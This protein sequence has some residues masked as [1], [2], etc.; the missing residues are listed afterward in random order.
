MISKYGIAVAGSA[1]LAATQAISAPTKVAVA[2]GGVR[3]TAA[4][5]VGKWA[6]EDDSKTHAFDCETDDVVVFHRAGTYY[7]GAGKGL[8]STDGV[9][10]KYYHRID[11]D[12]ETGEQSRDHFHVPL[13]TKVSWVGP[14]VFRESGSLMHRCGRH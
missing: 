6:G 2:K 5:L 11:F 14:N 10:I 12:T 3:V 1:L 9:R 7:D 8:Y 13:Y 4:Y